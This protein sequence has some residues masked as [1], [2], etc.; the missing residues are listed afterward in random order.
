MCLAYVLRFV[1]FIFSFYCELNCW[2][3]HFKY[4][5]F[6]NSV[7]K[8]FFFHLFYFHVYLLFFTQ[9]LLLKWRV[10][11]NEM[12]QH[13]LFAGNICYLIVAKMCSFRSFMCVCPSGTWNEWIHLNSRKTASIV[14]LHVRTLS[15]ERIGTVTVV[16][17][18]AV[19]TACS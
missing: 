2:P 10:G 9:K 1:C 14:N 6:L 3:F 18:A 16:T 17:K 4:L 11:F 5:L 13:S 15:W 8:C 7:Y 12:K 19:M